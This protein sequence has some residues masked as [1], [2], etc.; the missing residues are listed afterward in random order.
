[1][2]A[3]KR[4][5]FPYVTEPRSKKLAGIFTEQARRKRRRKRPSSAPH[6][7]RLSTRPF[8]GHCKHDPVAT[9]L[10]WGLCRQSKQVPYLSCEKTERD[11]DGIKEYFAAID[12]ADRLKKAATVA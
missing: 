10:L 5:R 1:M 12:P 3:K 2:K 4:T 8:A 6:F 9:H 7:L 11:A